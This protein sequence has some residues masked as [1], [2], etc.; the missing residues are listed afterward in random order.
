MSRLR[1]SQ[2]QMKAILSDLGAGRTVREVSG[3]YGISAKTLYRWRAKLTNGQQPNDKERLRSLETE[4]R[5]LK[6]EFA[7]L[8][9]DYVALR[10]ALI[11][12]CDGMG[13]C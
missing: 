7:Q 11:Q 4:H 12:R 8:T 13:D 1:F 10:A 5:R 9:L 2:N 6:K 3:E